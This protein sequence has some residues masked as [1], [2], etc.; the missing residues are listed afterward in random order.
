MAAT[1]FL[2]SIGS[3]IKTFF[4]KFLPI[5]KQVTDAAVKASP[6]V[7]IA[8]TA[9]G[10]PEAAALYNSV[11][12]AVQGAEAAAA[13]AGAQTGTGTQKAALVLSNP[14][15]QQ[16][17]TT[18]ESAVGVQAHTTDQQ[19][20]YINAVVQTLNTLNGAPATATQGTPAA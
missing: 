15:V 4:E 12:G 8:L 7:D 17:F 16:A 5:A 6:I 13:A 1:S 19:L 20:Q 18:F 3:R 11:S 9:S 10:H 14:V 2:S